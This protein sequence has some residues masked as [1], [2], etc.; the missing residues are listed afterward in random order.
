MHLCTLHIGN[1]SRGVGLYFGPIYGSSIIPKVLAIPKCHINPPSSAS[2][3]RSVI[4][5]LLN[6]TF[7]PKFH[8]QAYKRMQIWRCNR[9][10]YLLSH[11]FVHFSLCSFILLVLALPNFTS[12][13]FFA[14]TFRWD[15]LITPPISLVSSRVTL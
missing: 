2:I 7:V 4:Q 12:T 11:H 5:Q 10:P 15:F 1:K 3:T 6:S 9:Q 14:S 8:V 13:T